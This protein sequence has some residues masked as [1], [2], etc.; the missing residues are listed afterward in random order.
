MASTGLFGSAHRPGVY[1]V[2]RVDP[3][4]WRNG[5]SR[6]IVAAEQDRQASVDWRNPAVY[7]A[8]RQADRAAI[9]WEWLRRDPDYT[10]WHATASHA[11]RGSGLARQWGVHF[12]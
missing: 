4:F 2:D 1:G 11:T 3:G 7:D 12:R 10:A 9:M 5:V 6:L 8:L